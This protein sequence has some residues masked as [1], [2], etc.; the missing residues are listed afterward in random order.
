MSPPRLN[1]VTIP[2]HTIVI[3][4]GMLH[5]KFR[6]QQSRRISPFLNF[7]AAALFLSVF[8]VSVFLISMVKWINSVQ[9]LGR[10]GSLHSYRPKSNIHCKRKYRCRILDVR[11]GH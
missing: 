10:R 7:A 6:P 11:L 1:K 2:Y 5:V 8:L 9:R 3:A 4:I